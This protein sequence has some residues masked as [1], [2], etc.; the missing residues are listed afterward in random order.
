MAEAGQTDFWNPDIAVGAQCKKL[1]I[2]TSTDRKVA[3][4][5]AV[6]VHATDRVLATGE[7]L[8]EVHLLI[9]PR[10]DPER[11]SA[12]D[13][14]LSDHTVR[15]HPANAAAVH[16]KPDVAVGAGRDANREATT[17]AARRER[18]LDDRVRRVREVDTAERV[19]GRLSEPDVAPTVDGHVGHAE[20][21]GRRSARRRR[22][23]ELLDWAST[24]RNLSDPIS[25]RFGH[26][27]I[28]VGSR[29]DATGLLGS[30][31][32]GPGQRVLDEIR[33]VAGVDTASHV[34]SGREPHLPIWSARYRKP[35]A[36][37]QRQR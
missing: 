14:K 15:G 10:R 7:V 30:T 34:L 37:T 17:A 29:D 9:G 35:G 2:R 4:D 27:Q 16:R 36:A 18:E 28:P 20:L 32:Q 31:R 13:R 5:I 24:G 6:Q 25:D 19:A 1:R 12:G 23:C 21:R 3:R 33:R 22:R 11:P 8:A 26:P